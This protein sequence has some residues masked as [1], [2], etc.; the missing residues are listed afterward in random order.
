MLSLRYQSKR[1]D[2]MTQE[3]TERVITTTWKDVMGDSWMELWGIPHGDQA[4][5]AVCDDCGRCSHEVQDA[6]ENDTQAHNG[7]DAYMYTFIDRPKTLAG[8]HQI[9]CSDCA[10]DDLDAIEDAS[11]FLAQLRQDTE[12]DLH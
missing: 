5:D 4:N 1:S 6:Y 11:V 12:R 3:T 9:L 7:D 10:A 2:E 8:L